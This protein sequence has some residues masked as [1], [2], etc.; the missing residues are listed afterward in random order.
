M[1][2]SPNSFIADEMEQV[3]GALTKE[4]TQEYFSILGQLKDDA[5]ST[6]AP[7]SAVISQRTGRIYA[8]QNIAN[9]GSHEHVHSPDTQPWESSWNQI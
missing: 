2:V 5:H 6:V 8:A 7:I 9:G 1:S 3:H 4:I